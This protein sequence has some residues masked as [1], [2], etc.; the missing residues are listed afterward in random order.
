MKFLIRYT[1]G[2]DET[3]QIRFKEQTY[4]IESIDH[5]RYEGKW[6]EIKAIEVSNSS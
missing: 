4:N 2:L 5:I 6:M 3:M 1:E